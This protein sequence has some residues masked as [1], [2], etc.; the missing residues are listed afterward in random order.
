MP[1]PATVD[2][3]RIGQR[4]AVNMYSVAVY[5]DGANLGTTIDTVVTKGVHFAVC[6]MAT[7]FF[8]GMLA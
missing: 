3:P 8:A 1:P 6:Q 2:D 5:T 7:R 4:A